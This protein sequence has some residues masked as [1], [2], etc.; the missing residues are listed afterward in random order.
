MN[1]APDANGA[2]PRLS[3]IE[4]LVFGAGQVAYGAKVQVMTLVLLFYNQVLG[5]PAA[6]VSLTIS[7]TLIIDAFWDPLF[8]HLSDHMRTRWGRRHPMMYLS[9]VPI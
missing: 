2:L 8:G 3:L 6:L 1:A 9:A 7:A 5:V 4:K